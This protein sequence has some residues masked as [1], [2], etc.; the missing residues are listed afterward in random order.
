MKTGIV[1]LNYNDY[2]TTIKLIN[3]IREY[4]SI[5]YIVVV[6][7]NSTDDSYTELKNFESD[8]IFII[9]AGK[10]GGYSYGNNLGAKYLI[11]NY[12]L[13]YLI[14]ANPDVTFSDE[15]VSRVI[16]SI[17]INGYAAAT[18]VML[19]KNMN[20]MTFSK[21]IPSYSDDLVRCTFLI[22]KI[23]GQYKRNKQQM[24]EMLPGSLFIIRRDVFAEIKG[25]DEDVFLYCE[26]RILG[27]K[28]KRKGYRVQIIEDAYFVHDH[29]VSINKTL[30]KINQLKQLY[31]SILYFHRKYNDISKCQ[32]A[33]LR[34]MMVYNLL[35]KR[36]I[37]AVHC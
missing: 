25:F 9:Q 34:I 18:G 3:Q 32:Y 24:E 5:D 20:E 19:D 14:I 10:N 30:N 23:V 15:F 31:R 21:C 36:M 1:I 11:E 22:K 16:Q 13:D 7:N 4:K 35:I 2:S 28:L 27:T 12:C 33:L 17:D 8:K 6:D 29:A 26:E 37:F